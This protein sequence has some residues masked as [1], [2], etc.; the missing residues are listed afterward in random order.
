MC[1]NMHMRKIFSTVYVTSIDDKIIKNVYNLLS[2][3]LEHEYF[4][5]RP[6]YHAINRHFAPINFS[7]FFKKPSQE[8]Q[9]QKDARNLGH[10]LFHINAT[11][12]KVSE[13]VHVKQAA[14]SSPDLDPRFL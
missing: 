11:R 9:I 1:L 10:F 2:F 12:L 3:F 13:G 6:E 14:A 4:F 7:L 5:L 8:H